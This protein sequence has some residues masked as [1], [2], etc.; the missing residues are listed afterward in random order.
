MGKIRGGILIMLGSLLCA[1]VLSAAEAKPSLEKMLPE[2]FYSRIGEGNYQRKFYPVFSDRMAWEALSCSPLKMQEKVTLLNDAGKIL[3]RPMEALSTWDYFR[4]GMDGD[5]L[6]FELRYFNRRI[7]FGTLVLAL[8]LTGDKEKYLPAVI[9]R[10]GAI[11][12][13]PTWCAPAHVGDLRDDDPMPVPAAAE[14][15]DL[16]NAETAQLVAVT[17]QILGD[18]IKAVSPRFYELCRK[19]TLDRVVHPVLKQTFWWMDPSRERLNNWTPWCS[20]NVLMTAAILSDDPKTVEALIRKLMICNSAY[21]DRISADGYCDEGPGY[22]NKSFPKFFLFFRTLDDM[23]PG[24]GEKLFSEP[25]FRMM[26]DYEPNMVIAGSA[27]VTSADCGHVSEGGV[28]SGLIYDYGKHIH[29]AELCAFALDRLT[30]G[31][32]LPHQPVIN[33]NYRQ[34]TGDLLAAVLDFFFCVPETPEAEPGITLPPASFWPD[35]FGILRHPEGFSASLKA[36]HNNE[37]HNHNDLGHFTLYHGTRPIVI[38]LG[39]GIYSRKNFGPGRYDLYYTGAI[40]HNAL[41]FGDKI[42]QPGRQYCASLIMP[43]GRTLRSDLGRA[44]PEELKLQKYVRTLS[45]DA[46]A[47]VITDEFQPAAGAFL[48]LYSPCSV[49]QRSGME[50]DFGNGVLCR[51]EGGHCESVENVPEEDIPRHWGKQLKKIR[52]SAAASPLKLNFL[53]EGK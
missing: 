4:F 9:D 47:V 25:K 50:L 7:E 32:K 52:I 31:G 18:E 27:Y 40:G 42:Q 6:R 38:D 14:V 16:F 17:L 5:R 8:C 3:S 51:I 30:V 41:C 22:W 15:V 21:Y 46:D 49:T 33:Q 37:N 28:W 2:D 44:Y 45:C 36:G 1:G 23:V 11:M 24:A 43:D 29:S 35:R 13:E 39:T 10:L 12:A 53:C 34:G 48:T 26:G 20:G 19:N